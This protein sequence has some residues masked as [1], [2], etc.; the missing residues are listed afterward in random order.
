MDKLQFFKAIAFLE[1]STNAEQ[2]SIEILIPIEAIGC[3]KKSVSSHGSY[4]VILRP[5]FKLGL[6]ETIKSINATLTQ[7]QIQL[8]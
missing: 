2:S 5:D 7:T 6:E 8:I 1:R 3:L 4:E